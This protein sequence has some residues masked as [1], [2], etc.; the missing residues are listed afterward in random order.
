MLGSSSSCL[1]R[2][3][4]LATAVAGVD[5]GAG[6]RRA[7]V[8]RVLPPAAT[9]PQQTVDTVITDHRM[10]FSIST[11]QTVLWD[12]IQYSG[13][14]QR[15]RVGAA[16]QAGGGHR[17]CR[18]TT[19]IASLDAA[20]QTVIQGPTPSCGAAPEPGRQRRERRRG[21]RRVV[22][23]RRVRGAAGGRDAGASADG[24]TRAG[25]LRAGRR[26]VRRGDRAL[27]AGRG[28]RRVADR[29]RL[30]RAEADAADHRRVH[31][32]GL[33]LHRAQARAQARAC[34]RCSP[35]ASSRRAPT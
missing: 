22:R 31:H 2:G 7:R 14:R 17:S 27:V 23:Q 8:R 29:Q 5:G 18:R 35:C 25:R 6:A 20:T 1:L 34:R 3:L 12:Q 24:S 30:R 11:A 10:V 32:R 33:R 19:W 26:A 15:V 16:R 4:G 21:L 13:N 28:A 9:A